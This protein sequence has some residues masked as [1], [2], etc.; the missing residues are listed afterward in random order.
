[1]LLACYPQKACLFTTEVLDRIGYTVK[2]LAP[3][4][5]FENLYVSEAHSPGRDSLGTDRGAV[6]GASQ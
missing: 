1:M 4:V 2:Q 6:A 3:L 5:R